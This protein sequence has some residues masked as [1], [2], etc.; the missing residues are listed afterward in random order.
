MHDSGEFVVH[1]ADETLIPQVHAS[2]VE[3]P[4][5]VSEVDLLGLATLPG[6]RVRVPR[7]AVAP[8][9]MECKVHQVIPFGATGQLVR[10]RALARLAG[11]AWLAR[12]SVP[13][14]PPRRHCRQPVP[15]VFT[16]SIEVCHD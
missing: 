5:E 11:V 9:A 15:E 7:L 3:H 10:H 1:I 16:K 8:I 12:I 6:T 14:V 13:S 4:P 2:A